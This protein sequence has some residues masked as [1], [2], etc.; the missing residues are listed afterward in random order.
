LWGYLQFSAQFTAR[1][2]QHYVGPAGKFRQKFLL[3][4]VTHKQEFLC[5]AYRSARYR[6]DNV[7]PLL[8]KLIK[9]GDITDLFNLYFI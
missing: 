1:E 8:T 2:K 7:C 3:K 5:A 4:A 9:S 6:T